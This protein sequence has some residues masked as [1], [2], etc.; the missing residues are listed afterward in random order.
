MTPGLRTVIG[1]LRAR[2][3]CDDGF[4]MIEALVAIVLMA[5]GIVAV[6]TTFDAA[7][8]LSTQ[9][10]MRDTTDAIARGEIARIEALPWASIALA[11]APTANS[12][13]N[14]A[15]PASNDPTT[16]LS[17]ASCWSGSTSP[18]TLP[19]HCYQW[20]WS[21]S[22]SAEPLVINASTTDAT[23]NPYTL[24]D[25][26]NTSN[27]ATRASFSVYRFITYANDSECTAT[28]CASNYYKRI[29][30][31]VTCPPGSW[32]SHTDQLCTADLHSPV[33]INTLYVN[34]MGGSNSPLSYSGVHCLD[35]A[36]TVSC[37]E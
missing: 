29:T 21:S 24:T 28:A 22:S 26:I 32:T 15:V 3:G 37:T 9:A 33:V 16:Y 7:R 2:L 23:A 13:S 30:V 6:V 25:T 27:G 20:N 8:T 19:A 12:G 14:Q 4:T 31:A 36:S 18:V 1:R 35:G 17:T 5:V 34:P 10:E 11:S